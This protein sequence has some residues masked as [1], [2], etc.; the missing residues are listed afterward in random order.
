MKQTD[1]EN[2]PVHDNLQEILNKLDEDG[3]GDIDVRE[4]K[5]I[6]DY[7]SWMLRQSDVAL[8]KK[9]DLDGANHVC[10]QIAGYKNGSMGA[11]AALQTILPLL[12]T[13]YT[14][15]PYPRVRKI[16]RSEA[17]EQ[18]ELLRQEAVALRAK[19][20]KAT[21][22]LQKQSVQFSKTA[23]EKQNANTER[24][25]MLKEQL[26]ELKGNF[27]A[28]LEASGNKALAG[29][30]SAAADKEFNQYN[31]YRKFAVW[32]L[33]AAALLLIYIFYQYVNTT[34]TFRLLDFIQRL[35]L[36]VVFA[37]PALYF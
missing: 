36:S 8:I 22:E 2:H 28:L 12:T 3:S 34:E 31:S 10:N 24:L 17:N 25:D 13:F 21:Q 18:L 27:D 5:A 37:L 29:G 9:D 19:F 6:L 11:S 35:P 26:A 15:L 33:I 7:M 1:Y 4:L 20:A 23:N 32:T 14:K 30:L 16:F